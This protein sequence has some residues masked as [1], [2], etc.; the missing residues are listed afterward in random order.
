MEEWK[1]AKSTDLVEVARKIGFTLVKKGRGYSTKEIDSLMIYDRSTW[2]RFSGRLENG[3]SG[4]SQVDF[5]M[6]FCNMDRD[7]AVMWLLDFAGSHERN[8]ILP[9]TTTAKHTLKDKSQTDEKDKKLILPQRAADDRRLYGYLIKKRGISRETVDY[10]INKQ[11]IYESLINHNIIFLGKDKEGSNRS[12][13]QRGTFDYL[14]T[15]FKGDVEGSDKIFGF[16][17]SNIESTEISIFEGGI[18]LMSYY[19]LLNDIKPLEHLLALGM[20][21]DAPLFRYLKDYPDIK[22]ILLCL[23]NDQAGRDAC[24]H[25]KEKYET[26]GYQIINHQAPKEYKDYN[27]FLL[28]VKEDYTLL[29]KWWLF[30][31][32]AKKQQD[33]NVEDIFIN[34]CSQKSKR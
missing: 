8:S 3:I 16:H 1:T 30:F 32:E 34:S 13:S 9:N 26:L 23:D 19:E 14:N 33:M 25:I 31:S 20:L 17:L 12:A 4:G 18:D 24:Q 15:A 2:N 5:L 11:L 21:H 28:A 29:K 22:T 7:E 10:F 27:E 6:A